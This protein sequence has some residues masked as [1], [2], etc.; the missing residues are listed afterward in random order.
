MRYHHK[1][2]AIYSRMYG[3]RYICDHPVYSVGTLFRDGNKG[4]VVIQQRFD[5][6]TKK[7][8]WDEID[9]W[10]TDSIYLNPGFKQIFEKRAGEG[11]DGLY[12]TVTVRQLMWTLRMKPIPK[13]KWETVF[14]RRDI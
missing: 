4:L 9:P 2:P 14:D 5:P 10:L 7:T 1:K 8:W 12:P 6:E 11:R 3:E 13:E